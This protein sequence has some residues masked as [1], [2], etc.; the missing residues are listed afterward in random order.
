MKFKLFDVVRLLKD[1]S[2][3]SVFTGEV[4]TIVEVYTLPREGYELEFVSEG[5]ITKALFAVGPDDIELCI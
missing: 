5:G 3:E 2:D 4:A 1:F